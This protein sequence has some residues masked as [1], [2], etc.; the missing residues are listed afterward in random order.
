MRAVN[1]AGHAR[2]TMS[3][4][5]GAFVR[6][7]CEKVRAVLQS[8]NIL[9]ECP[10]RTCAPTMRA[11]T[12]ELR[13]LLGEEPQIVLRTVHEI[14]GIVAR[15]PFAGYQ[16]TPRVKFYVAFLAERP[17]RVPA[18]PVSSAKEML[19]AIAIADRDV[20]IVS[21]IKKTGFFGFPNNFIEEA[22]GVAAT[23][24]N[25]STVRKIGTLAME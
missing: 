15:A 23:T 9:F 5:Q 6:A 4:V 25:W 20:F 17:R 1:V 16:L 7:G 11:V 12:Q 2:V 8:G 10:A 24:R 21:R 3:A 14:A 18:F 19:E 13:E 22:L